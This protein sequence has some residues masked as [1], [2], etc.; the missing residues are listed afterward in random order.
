MPAFKFKCAI[1]LLAARIAL[2]SAASRDT[3]EIKCPVEQILKKIPA[4]VMVVARSGSIKLREKQGT[5]IAESCLTLT[6]GT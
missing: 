3:V 4:L 2:K 6:I 1:D 5:L